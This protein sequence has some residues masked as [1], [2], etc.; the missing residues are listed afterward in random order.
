MLAHRADRR[1]PRPLPRAPRRDQPD[2]RHRPGAAEDPR[3]ARARRRRAARSA[4]PIEEVILATNPTLEGEATAMYL[5]R[6]A[7]GPT[8]AL[9]TRIARGLP[10]GGDL[11]YADDVTLIRALQGRREP[12]ER[13][14]ARLRDPAAPGQG[15]GSAA[16]LGLVVWLIAVGPLGAS[17]SVELGAAVLALSARGVHPP[18]PGEP[19]LTAGA[20]LEP[21]VR[22]RLTALPARSLSSALAPLHDRGSPPASA[23]VRPASGHG[24][25]DPRLTRRSGLRH[26]E[27][28]ALRAVKGRALHLNN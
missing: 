27:Q 14:R 28:S 13:A 20:A 22:G 21:A 12:S 8:S 17:A 2:R 23:G 26:H 16:L 24:R 3:A 10:V 1:V 15:A 25:R 7:G 18:R 5:G 4:S 19:D 9:V 11:E 6:A